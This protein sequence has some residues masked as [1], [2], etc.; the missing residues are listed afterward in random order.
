[1]TKMMCLPY[2][3]AGAGVYRPWQRLSSPRLEAVPIQLP[4]REEEFTEP[5]YTSVSEAVERTTAR[6]RTAA[7]SDRFVL[8]GHSFGAVLAFEV[9]QHLLAI[10]GPLPEHVI[11][12]GAVSPRRRRQLKVSDV[13]DE[14]AVNDVQ[15]MTGRSVEALHHPELRSLLLPVMRA[16]VRLLSNYVPTTSEPLPMPLT[17]MRGREDH[18][19]PVPDW[20]D[21]AA[22]AAGPFEAV[23]MAGGHMYLTDDWPLIWKTVEELL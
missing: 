6:I 5:F 23:E 2:A 4:G 15:A 14:Q 17:A 10:G 12:S 20:L 21:W 11:V 19:V 16:D 18:S 1:M 22:F 13:D 8:F 3:G 9:T 7:G